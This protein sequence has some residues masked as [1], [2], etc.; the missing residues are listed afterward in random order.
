MRTTL[1]SMSPQEQELPPACLR[2]P[3]LL[4]FCGCACMWRCRYVKVCTS[5]QV[6]V[7]AGSCA[8]VCMY[9]EK[10]EVNLWCIIPQDPSHAG[11][12]NMVFQRMA[13]HRFS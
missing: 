3:C 7:C 8:H 10:S 5:V 6:H 2:Q 13:M 1:K 11:F 12:Q 4:V 9:E